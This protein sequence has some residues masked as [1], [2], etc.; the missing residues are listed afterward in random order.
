MLRAI[1]HFSASYGH[2]HIGEEIILAE[3]AD[4][5]AESGLRSV[6]GRN[7]NDC[8]ILG[9]AEVLPG[10]DFILAP[11]NVVHGDPEHA[12]RALRPGEGATDAILVDHC[13]F[14]RCRFQGIVFALSDAQMNLFR[15]EFA[16]SD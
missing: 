3:L 12:F 15:R 7:F 14:S 16:T 1:G 9:P 8:L 5:S 2:H 6:I 4:E 13:Q 10:L 11:L